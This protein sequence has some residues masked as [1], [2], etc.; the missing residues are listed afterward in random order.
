M[1]VKLVLLGVGVVWV[2][3]LVALYMRPS[4]E[5]VFD[6][7]VNEVFDRPWLADSRLELTVQD[8]EGKLLPAE[9]LMETFAAGGFEGTRGRRLL[10]FDGR[11][12]IELEKT[13]YVNMYIDSQGYGMETLEIDFTELEQP[14]ERVAGTNKILIKRDVVLYSMANP[15]RLS[16][17]DLFRLGTEGAERNYR[18]LQLRDSTRD[19]RG[20]YPFVGIGLLWSRAKL[21]S[22]SFDDETSPTIYLRYEDDPTEEGIPNPD[23]NSPGMRFIHPPGKQVVVQ[24][25]GF[26]EGDGLVF[27]GIFGRKEHRFYQLLPEAPESGYVHSYVLSKEWFLERKAP[28]FY[29]RINGFY[30]KLGLRCSTASRGG[31]TDYYPVVDGFVQ[32]NLEGNRDLRTGW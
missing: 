8:P 24:L 19:V 29:L 20:G 14:V 12:V 1:R 9:V 32:S 10:K 26:E 22:L 31:Y 21:P 27:S 4:E 5:L 13:T 3:I 23:P 7:A 25:H 2:L 15:P 6:Q 11:G 16:E 30:S 18:V 17:N 28:L